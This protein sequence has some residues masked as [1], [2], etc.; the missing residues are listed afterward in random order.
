MQIGKS[1][2]SRQ[3]PLTQDF[4]IYALSPYKHGIE[5]V[6]REPSCLFTLQ[7]AKVDKFFLNINI[8][9][10]G[11]SLGSIHLASNRRKR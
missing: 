9:N 5:L 2:S 6:N 1:L 8:F 7:V 4:F 10:N 11:S 3:N